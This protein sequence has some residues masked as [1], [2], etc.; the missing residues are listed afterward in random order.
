MVKEEVPKV[1]SVQ[2][3]AKSHDSHETKIKPLTSILREP[4]KVIRRGSGGSV[5][6]MFF[7]V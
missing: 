4:A 5:F 2:A 6:S 1:N 3:P 7:V